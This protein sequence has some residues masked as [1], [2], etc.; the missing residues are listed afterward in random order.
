[1]APKSHSIFLPL[2]ARK[3]K[4]PAMAASMVLLSR[5]NDSFLVSPLAKVSMVRTSHSSRF[6]Q[7]GKMVA[8]MERGNV[9]HPIGVILIV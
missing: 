8:R 5:W 2:I 6:S 9:A 7:S 4:P 3:K 1:M